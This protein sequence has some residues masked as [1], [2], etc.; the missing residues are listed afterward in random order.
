VSKDNLPKKL[1]KVA[2][3]AAK[4]VGD[5]LY[6]ID[7]KQYGKEFF[8]IEVNDN[9]TIMHGLEDAKDRDIYEKIILALVE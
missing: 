6:G 7:A 3:K 4:S 8:V 5:G 1:K 9:P 2:L